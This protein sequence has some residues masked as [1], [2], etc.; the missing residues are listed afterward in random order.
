MCKNHRNIKK[1]IQA[2]LC[3]GC[4]TCYSFCPQGCIDIVESGRGIFQPVIDEMKCRN[5]GICVMVCGNNEFFHQNDFHH[6]D[7]RFIG[8]V[9][10]CY[11]GYSN[12]DEIRMNSSSGGLI[13]Q[14]SIFCLEN[15]IVDGVICVDKTA[16][17][18]AR[19]EAR[20]CKTTDQ[21][22]TSRKSKYIPVPL[23]RILK[24]IV[25]EREY[26]R[27]LFIGLPCH[28]KGLNNAANFYKT[29]NEK[30]ILKF[31]IFCSHTP[32]IAGTDFLIH[33][34]PTQKRIKDIF[35]R[36]Q[37]WKNT[38]IIQNEAGE[39]VKYDNYWGKYFG[40]NFFTPKYCFFCD[41]LF[42][43]ECDLSFGDAWL[44]EYKADKK[45]VSLIISRSS[46][47]ENLLHR[48]FQADKVSVNNIGI[49]KIVESQREYYYFKFS[50]LNDRRNKLLKI[51][52]SGKSYLPISIYNSI[53]ILHAQLSEYR[54]FILF[55]KIVP[56]V[57]FKGYVKLIRRL[58]S[59]FMRKIYQNIAGDKDGHNN[60]YN[61]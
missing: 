42:A 58:L 29:L 27:Y 44:E 52:Q 34:C 59:F 18:P 54:F 20:I 26:N 32:T 31:G 49:E 38:F 14:L 43:R 48:S 55:L 25:N 35:Y 53:M 57:F 21:V 4:S 61:F 12:C 60:C 41:D 47:G 46:L 51:R 9:R 33:Q 37:G 16:E 24:D 17:N 45:G 2:Q 22:R 50:M 19:F 3:T 7:Q 13:T 23:N 28:L 30:I 11:A 1:I 5:C 36:D 15:K 8:L 39:V 40:L 56:D 10:N 6:T